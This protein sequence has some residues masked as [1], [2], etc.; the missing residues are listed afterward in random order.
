M[1]EQPIKLHF[2]RVRAFGIG[3]YWDLIAIFY[4]VYLSCWHWWLP[5]VPYSMLRL[6]NHNTASAVVG[7]HWESQ[8]SRFLLH[9]S[10]RCKQI[11]HRCS[12]FIYWRS[13]QH[14]LLHSNRI[15]L[16]A[17]QW[18]TT[19]CWI[20]RKYCKWNLQIF[21]IN[22]SSNFNYTILCC[23]FSDIVC[24]LNIIKA[25]FSCRVS[26]IR[27]DMN[28]YAISLYQSQLFGILGNSN[29]CESCNQKAK[30]KIDIKYWQV[31]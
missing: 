30:T 8:I 7:Y 18:W 25:V 21:K 1:L 12:C 2:I 20:Q 15:F 24:S 5:H 13:Y 29:I 17:F 16:N 11:I 23:L 22:V 28:V 9:L 19:L 6:E 26:S 4:E 31:R 10:Q 3:A 27:H 14:N